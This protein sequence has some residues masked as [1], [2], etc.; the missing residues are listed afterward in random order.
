MQTGEWRVEGAV[1]PMVET[2][3]LSPFLPS[4]SHP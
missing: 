1:F 3:H 4:L 2:L